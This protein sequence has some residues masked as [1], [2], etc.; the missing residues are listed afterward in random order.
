MIPTALMNRILRNAVSGLDAVDS[1]VYPTVQTRLRATKVGYRKELVREILKEVR[2]RGNEVQLTYRPDDSEN[3]AGRRRQRSTIG[4][5]YTVSN[6]G[7]DG[8]R[9]HG[10]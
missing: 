7:A 8:S 10:L 9:T 6:G 3:P 5:L 1:R 2:V 4:V